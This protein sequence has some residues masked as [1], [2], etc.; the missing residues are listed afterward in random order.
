MMAGPRVLA[1]GHVALDMMFYIDTFPT[2]PTKVAAHRFTQGVG[3]ASANAAVAA[4]RLGAQVKFVGLTGADAA[5]AQFIE[6]FKRE[7]VDA[8]G[9]QTVAG[10]QSSVSAIVI[11]AAGERLIVNRRGDALLADVAFAL[12]HLDGVDVVLA[13]PR[14]PTWSAAALRGARQRG[15]PTVLD[16]EVAPQADLQMLVPLAEW[17]VFSKPG[18]DAFAPDCAGDPQRGLARALQAGAR[19]AAVTLG[20]QGLW[21]Q[22]AGQAAQYLAAWPVDKVVDTTG[23]GDT[24]HGALGVALV[25][26]YQDREALMFA[27]VAAALKCARPGGILGA[28]SLAQVQQSLQ[29]VLQKIQTQ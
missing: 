14:S 15:V 25:S 22:R 26:G 7:G 19:V 9:L 28:P 6:H 2:T 18:M 13:D 24:F 11:D 21:W 27:S 29:Q 20:A 4:A 12:Q 23:A 1:V 10:C 16:A 17:A 3:G 5:V 8:S